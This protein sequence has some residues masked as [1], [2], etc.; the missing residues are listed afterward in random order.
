MNAL[1]P[2]RTPSGR[3]S[4]KVRQWGARLCTAAD[5]SELHAELAQAFLDLGFEG[6]SV[7]QCDPDHGVSM[8]WSRMGGE[9]V[10]ADDAFSTAKRDVLASIDP[11]VHHWIARQDR[12]LSQQDFLALDRRVYGAY[13]ELP[14]DFGLQPWRTKLSIP[15]LG[16]TR[17]L[18]VGVVSMAPF[19]F[20]RDALDDI[21][22][23]AHT[24]C[25]LDTG[26]GTLRSGADR[27]VELSHE[28]LDCLRWAAAGK[29]Y[30]DISAILGVT[31][32]AVRY[33]LNGARKQY[34]FAT[35]IQTI[36]QSA[37]DHDFDPMDAR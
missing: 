12:V 37:K 34:G 5:D 35:V 4:R 1:S 32:R 10:G 13:M 28:Q 30:D 7:M 27:H 8:R 33:H 16:D 22:F 19:D 2:V 20:Y 24:Y 31:E 36:V 29:S 15:F 3:I 25:T 14:R 26:D 9:P 23:L 21:R 18:S 11:S 6:L 17:G